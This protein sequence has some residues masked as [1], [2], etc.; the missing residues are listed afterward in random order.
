MS[1]VHWN[2]VEVLWIR[3]L[4]HTWVRDFWQHHWFTCRTVYFFSCISSSMGH[5]FSQGFT[6]SPG[7]MAPWLPM[8][9][10]VSQW[11]PMAH[12]R[13]LWLHMFAYG[14]IWHPMASYPSYASTWL[15]VSPYES[16]WLHIGPC[17]S[18]LLPM[19]PDVCLRIPISNFGFL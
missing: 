6:Q 4:F 19:T 13:S 14:C 5:K 15:P 16:L 7:H 12:F 18:L 3:H 10:F 9:T 17:V 2:I 8:T 11:L 1:Y